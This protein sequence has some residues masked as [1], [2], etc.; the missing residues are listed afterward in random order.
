MPTV[1][2]SEL[3]MYTEFRNRMTFSASLW[4]DNLMTAYCDRCARGGPAVRSSP[5]YNLLI[6]LGADPRG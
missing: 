5:D 3:D 2:Y 6:N 1:N 4:S